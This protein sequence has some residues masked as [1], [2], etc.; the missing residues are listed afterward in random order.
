MRNGKIAKLPGAVRD[1]LNLRMA[2]GEESPTLLEWLN[3]LDKVR[4]TLEAGFG[5]A[6]ISKQN[7]CEWRQGG[8]REWQR[9]HELALQAC[10]LSDH[11][12]DM[13]ELVDTPLLAGDMA[14]IVTARYAALV[15][16][17]DGAA[18]R[19][20]EEKLRLLRVLNRDIALMQ[21]TLQ[22]ANLQKIEYH[23]HLEDEEAKDTAK[24]NKMALS[25][26]S[27]MLERNSWERMFGLYFESEAAQRL[28]QFVVDVKFDQPWRKTM[29]GKGGPVKPSQT[30]SNQKEGLTGENASP[31]QAAVS[32]PETGI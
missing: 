22:R 14:A 12:D 20:F 7:L 27:A 29:G 30:Q 8:F 6:P 16:D 2:N 5:G 25:P 13:A 24:M 1:E 28:A 4:E 15:N 10:Q 3:G 31:E 19:D 17:W 21:R 18:G 26:I 32:A 9:Y 11:A 23:Q